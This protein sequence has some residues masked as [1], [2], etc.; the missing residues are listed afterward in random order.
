MLGTVRGRTTSALTAQF[1]VVGAS[2]GGCGSPATHSRPQGRRP[3]A[4]PSPSSCPTTQPHGQKPPAVALRDTSGQAI[5]SPDDHGWIGEGTLWT[6][7]PLNLPAWK[8]KD[9]GLVSVKHP[10]FRAEPG[11]VHV[12]GKPIAGDTAVFKAEMATADAYGLTGFIPSI[13]Q[14]GHPGCWTIVAT[15]ND[16]RLELVI[17]VPAPGEQ[18]R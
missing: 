16:D 5:G 9:T 14:F 4:I 6:R 8:D 7:L 12:S 18:P 17:D 10:W 15:L 2:V 3:P 13:L 11:Q 1:V